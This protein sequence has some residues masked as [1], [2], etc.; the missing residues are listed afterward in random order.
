MQKSNHVTRLYD[1]HSIPLVVLALL[2]WAGSPASG[3]SMPSGQ[4][5][6]TKGWQIADM[7]KFLDTH[8]E[9]EEQLRKDPSLIRNDEFVENHPALQQYLHEHPGIREEFNENPKA[10]M[11]QEQRYERNEVSDGRN[12]GGDRDTTR[13][14]LANT[15]RFLDSHPEIAEQLQKDPSLIKNKQFVENHPALEEFLKTHPGA[16]EEFTEN[17]NAFMRGERRFDRHEDERDRDR[18]TGDR[19]TTR[20]ELANT[21]RFLDTHPEI[22][23]QLKKDPSLIKN[24][25]FVEKHPSLQEFLQTHPEVREEA[26]EN[27]NAFV[28]QE[29]RF[30]R[31]EDLR[32]RDASL[33]DRN[34]R[35]VTTVGDVTNVHHRDNGDVT[36]FGQFLGG[37]AAVAQQLSK[38][39]SLANNKEFL[40]NH[41]DL[42]DYLKSHPGVKD[43]L[44]KNP[45]AA[46]TSATPPATSTPTDSKLEPKHKQ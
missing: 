3:Q 17:P 18:R 6:D 39:P 21:D 20:A 27:P 7:D 9:V 12:W 28:R 22:A 29:R 24:K 19:D 45:Q 36:T 42:Q 1:L 32:N 31:H 41:P 33:H 23:E 30:D 44:V 10:F 37:H 14:E 35:D 40:A 16:R 13:A 15:D 8:P 4:A 5:N 46:I 11:R 2:L 26:R 38:D 43:E 25:E 34:H